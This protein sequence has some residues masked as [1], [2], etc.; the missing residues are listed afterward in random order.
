MKFKRF[1]LIIIILLMTSCMESITPEEA[2]S[3][4]KT[5]S[6]SGVPSGFDANSYQGCISGSGVS[7][8]ST[9]INFSFPSDADEVQILRDGVQV[10]SSYSSGVVSFQDAGLFEGKTY[11]YTC[12]AVFGTSQTTGTNALDISTL[13]VN[14]PQF[15]GIATASDAVGGALLT[16]GS[17]YG[18]A[19]TDHFEIYYNPGTTI[20]W[21]LSAKKEITFSEF[22]TAIDDLGDE[23]PFM[24]GVKACTASGVCDSNT[25]S[26]S[27]VTVDAGAPTTVGV[28]AVSISNG[29]CTLTVPWDLTKG[30]VKKRNVYQRIGA[31]GGTDINDYILVKV[32]NIADEDIGDPGTT[33]VLTGLSENTTYHFIVRD[34]GPSFYESINTSVVS[35]TTGDLTPPIFSGIT[36]LLNGSPADSVLTLSFTAINS[37]QVDVNGAFEYNIYTTEADLP[38]TPADPCTSGVEKTSLAANLYVSGNLVTY[39][40]TGLNSRKAYRVCVKASDS[41]GNYSNTGTYLSEV[42]SDVTPPDFD[43]VQNVTFDNTNS[44]MVVTWNGS[45]SSDIKDYKVKIWNSADAGSSVTLTRTHADYQS[46]FSF[47]SAEFPY[48][49]GNVI[50]VVVNACD[51]AF[52]DYGLVNCTA[53]AD[54]FAKSVT[55]PDVIPPSNFLGISSVGACSPNTDGCIKASWP[56]P[57]DFGDYVGLKIYE[58]DVSDNLTWIKD[59]QCT[60][61]D[62]VTNPLTS[63][64]ITGLGVG[65]TVYLYARGYDAT[66]NLT[67]VTNPW[68]NRQ[69]GRTGDFTAPNFISGLTLN[70]DASG[71][72]IG[73]STGLDNQVSSAIEPGNIVTY[74]LYRKIGLDTFSGAS[75]VT[76]APDGLNIK[77]GTDLSFLDPKAGLVSGNTYHYTVCVRDATPNRYCD[78]AIQSIVLPDS[79]P[80]PAF[81][82]I[83]SAELCDVNDNGCAKISWNAP[84]SWS[85]YR[86]FKVYSVADDDSLTLIKLCECSGEDCP[87]QVTSCEVT[88]LSIGR[89]Y[90]FYVRAYDLLNNLTDA[91]S[92][93]ANRRTVRT[94][95]ITEPNF[96]SG[97]AVAHQINPTSGVN[98]A[99]NAASDNQYAVN[100]FIGYKIYRR[101]ATTFSGAS[102][103]AKAPDGDLIA[104]TTDLTYF[105]D[106]AAL[107]E[108]AYYYYTVCAFDGT[109]TPNVSCDG[110]IQSI[111]V[112]DMS[113]PPNFLG[114]F[115]A[116]ICDTQEN[117]CV[118]VSWIAPADWTDYAGFEI[119]SVIADDTTA[120]LS[121]C[122]CVDDDC[123]TNNLTS[124]EIVLG[125]AGKTM[126]Y[127]VIAYDVLGNKTAIT[128]PFANSRV[129]KTDDVTPPTFTSFMTAAHQNGP[130]G[131]IIDWSGSFES[132]NQYVEVGNEIYFKV[133]RK[134]SS[135]FIFT[136]GLPDGNLIAT[137]TTKSHLD[138]QAGL[139]D[140]VAHYYTVCAADTAEN[141]YCDENIKSVSVSDATPPVILGATVDITAPKSDE[142]Y[143]LSWTLSDNASDKSNI[144]VVVRRKIADNAT[145]FPTVADAIIDSGGGLE[146]STDYYNPSPDFS[147]WLTY[148]ITAKDE[149]GLES[150]ATIAVQ[151]SGARITP[152]NRADYE[153]TDWVLEHGTT[154]IIEIPH[155]DPA[156]QLDSLTMNGTSRIEHLG[157]S[158]T[159]CYQ[160]D[161]NVAGDALIDGNSVLSGAGKG[162]LGC[163]IAGPDGVLNA[164]AGYGDQIG[165]ADGAYYYNGGAHGGKSGVYSTSYAYQDGYGD[166]Y[167]PND[168]GA[169]GGALN[170]ITYMG[171]NGG[172]VIKLVV[173]GT[174][175]MN[176]ELNVDGECTT[177]TYGGCG[178]A[179]SI[180]VSADVLTTTALTPSFYAR[181]GDRVTA[182]GGNGAGGAG[183]RIAIYYNTISNF[184]LIDGLTVEMFGGEG[185]YGRY[186]GGSG[187]LFYKGAADN[188]GH[189]AI[190]GNTGY[191]N[192]TTTSYMYASVTYLNFPSGSNNIFDSLFVSTEA[193]VLQQNTTFKLDIR[194][195]NIAGLYVYLFVPSNGSDAPVHDSNWF[196]YIEGTGVVEETSDMVGDGN[197]REY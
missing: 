82:G 186:I 133:Y 173:A 18:G 67:T 99:W 72:T 160:I 161:L 197:L 106:G 115:N 140:G 124:C 145:D 131:N 36:N 91:V 135:T 68:I 125:D 182:V 75:I 151:I 19:S 180:W 94:G 121:N 162:Y 114:I 156:L 189:L 5:D 109:P 2:L 164:G 24:F 40:M 49:S 194:E 165:F 64:S 116:G 60:S 20:D 178:A 132:D 28:T 104:I 169:G 176:G 193:K 102:I 126:N 157:C 139:S 13:V 129:S 79:D 16:W 23:L 181:G 76:N 141:M 170:N 118:K 159:L 46:G 108:N 42:T 100:N 77:T 158:T 1:I 81:L 37:Q 8:S 93:Y 127:Y 183:G 63:C 110:M 103:T 15:S 195:L 26:I 55:L 56:A 187:T 98:I 87:D 152:A 188:D 89:D 54:A 192:T 57:A 31:V 44:K 65:K 50:N 154:V 172:G 134:L 167:Q 38:A 34:E 69:S 80:P 78:G 39:D 45:S 179:G 117:G 86:G 88:G 148:L 10:Y 96:N 84:A 122:G 112:P 73:W 70:Q 48:T 51:N 92:P 83:Q 59:C 47:T 171:A 107:S 105:D 143:T 58:V 174:L 155:D 21:S 4:N 147:H 14:P 27:F 53:I 123:S 136:A 142:V 3:I 11:H 6:D 9:L 166:I 119:Y 7:I 149:A 43:G 144:L 190:I 138:P 29:Q 22:T 153:N 90:D 191:Y 25:E 52:P 113:P 71:V 111:E 137:L 33:I 120:M 35:A 168:H 184:N 175:T 61:S 74:E 95:D 41:D 128:N 17:P 146:V 62:C 196:E 177:A 101:E 150:T 30:A 85:D 32:E 185:T 66:N 97:L 163:N 130:D 12:R